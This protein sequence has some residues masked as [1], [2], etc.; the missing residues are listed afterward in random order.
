M[1]KKIKRHL[2]VYLRGKHLAKKHKHARKGDCVR[3]GSCCKIWYRCPFLGETVNGAFCKIYNFR[4]TV[5][6]VFPSMKKDLEEVSCKC[7]FKFD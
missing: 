5:C 4:S 3:C 6:R 1:I 7:G 2:N